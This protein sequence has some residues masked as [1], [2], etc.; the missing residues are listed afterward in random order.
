MLRSLAIALTALGRHPLRTALTTLS[1]SVGI[2]AVM[3]I[4][5]L[6]EGSR[7]Q[8]QELIADMGEDFIWIEAGGR[9]IG[10]VW[11]G[12]RG[13]RTLVVEDAEAIVA[14]VPD[15]VACSPQ[16]DGREQVIAAARNWNTRYQGVNADFFEIR[17]WATVRGAPFSQ[18]D[19]ESAA[20]VA[21][22]GSVVAERLFGEEDP[23][24]KTFRLGRYPYRVVGVLERKGASRTG[25]ERD[26][27]VILPHTTARRYLDGRY[28][29]DDIVCSVRSPEVVV[30]AES[31]LVPLLRFRHGLDFE[32]EDD[33]DI[34]RPLEALELRAET[35]RR[36]TMML[37]AIA[38]VSLV[39]GGVGIMNIMLV[40]VTERTYE[41][42]LRLAVGATMGA[43][44]QQFVTEAALLGLAGGTIGVIA[45]YTASAFLSSA[46]GWEASAS[47]D[48]AVLA[49]AIAGAAA[50]VFG[51]YPAHRA[52]SL[53]PVNALRAEV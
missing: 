10:G 6:G 32:D 33:F 17:R 53:D 41:I 29:L 39:V 11:T 43:I 20:R 36:M 47:T 49:V 9:N 23:V 5:A 22:L 18:Y 15:I 46:Y 21:V 35:T 37:T 30:R 44:R 38:A 4:V 16:V 8:V 48:I 3:C 13:A 26:D 51:Y 1:I 50:V 14:S 27:A 52:S 25:L 28:W 42:G 45:G 24:G 7:Q 2:A 31:Q 19:L 34:R 40:S 12:S